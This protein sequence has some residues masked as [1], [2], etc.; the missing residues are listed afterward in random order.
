MHGCHTR[1]PYP[2]TF[3]SSRPQP[4]LH[5]NRCGLRLTE[6]ARRHGNR[7][8]D[9]PPTSSP[10]PASGEPRRQPINALPPS[11]PC[12]PPSRSPRP[13]PSFPTQPRFSVS[14]TAFALSQLLPSFF[15]PVFPSSSPLLTS[16]SPSSGLY[17]CVLLVKP[18]SLPPRAPPP[19]CPPLLTPQSRA[20]I[21]ASRIGS[22]GEDLTH[23]LQFQ[24]FDRAAQSPIQAGTA[25]NNR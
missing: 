19:L 2:P 12:P 24:P 7:R 18:T 4:R 16:S 13:R 23:H 11:P 21:P 14:F 20:Q 25:I 17:K 22:D 1:Y 8:A 3:T 5:G 15:A 9:A 10:G 6:A